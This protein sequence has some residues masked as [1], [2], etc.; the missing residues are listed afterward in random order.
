ML[1]EEQMLEV[2]LIAYDHEPE[3]FEGYVGEYITYYAIKSCKS[4]VSDEELRDKIRQLIVDFTLRRL[5]EKGL[6]EATL[7]DDGSTSYSA[8]SGDED[9]AFYG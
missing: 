2:C 1:N 3:L 6:V 4:D 9:E 5:C 7:E 8:S